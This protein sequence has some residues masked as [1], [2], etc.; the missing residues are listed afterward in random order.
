M[1]QVFTGV[2]LLLFCLMVYAQEPSS[3]YR[4]AGDEKTDVSENKKGKAFYNRRAIS[5]RNGNDEAINAFPDICTT[6]SGRP[7]GTED[8]DEPD[9]GPTDCGNHTKSTKVDGTLNEPGKGSNEVRMH[10][11]ED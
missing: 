9:I 1:K 7:P 5:A 10:K 4:Y 2:I 6:P 8:T 11:G 3:G